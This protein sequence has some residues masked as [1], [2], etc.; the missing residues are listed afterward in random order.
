MK[1]EVK[2]MLQDLKDKKIAVTKIES[3]LKISSGY[4]W[5]VKEGIKLLS[6]DKF[7][8][9]KKYHAKIVGTVFIPERKKVKTYDHVKEIVKQLNKPVMPKGLSLSQQL[10]WREKNG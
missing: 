2:K 10:E 8:E 4:L 1:T 5:K 7:N 9:L 6:E 3:D